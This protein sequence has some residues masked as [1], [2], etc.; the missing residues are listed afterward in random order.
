MNVSKLSIGILIL[1]LFLICKSGLTQEQPKA[2]ILNQSQA[3]KVIKDLITYDGL[4]EIVKIQEAQMKDLRTIL[5]QK[6]TIIS[7]YQRTT[8]NNESIIS[9]NRVIF[10][11]QEQ[12]YKDLNKKYVRSVRWGR[13]KVVLLVGAIGYGLYQTLK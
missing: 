9:S 6:D 4:K 11:A 12:K 10:E 2:V 7:S 1:P 13:F 8:T 3:V 5:A